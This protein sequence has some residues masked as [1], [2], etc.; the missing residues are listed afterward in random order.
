MSDV[1][2]RTISP[3]RPNILLSPGLYFLTCNFIIA[4][5][6]YLRRLPFI[7][8]EGTIVHQKYN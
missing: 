1:G 8:Q 6:N 2:R 5:L 4:M 3:V 7:A